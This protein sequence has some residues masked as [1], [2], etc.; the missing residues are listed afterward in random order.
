MARFKNAWNVLTASELPLRIRLTLIL[1]PLGRR[2]K[3]LVKMRLPLGD[4]YLE[5]SPLGIDHRVFTEIFLDGSY[6]T[7][8]I[9]R[10]VL[11]LGAHRGY[12]GAYALHR[13][14]SRVVS[15]EPEARN[16]ELLRRAADSFVSRGSTWEVEHA[17]VGAT[18]GEALLRLRDQSWGH[19]LVDMHWAKVTGTQT[20]AVASLEHGLRRFSK[21]EGPLIVKIDI[22][23]SEGALVMDTPVEAWLPVSELFL[24]IE[25]FC[26][27]DPATLVE[28][29][30]AT[31]LHLVVQ[32]SG[33]I[34]H[35]VR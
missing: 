14:A 24:E 25:P 31:G 34:F 19:T 26:P 17:A 29:L 33:N 11:D 16:F 32:P 22:E 3:R 1:A 9:A 12:F 10:P 27:V 8:Y 7:D 13:G 5:P 4:C 15:Y 20:V 28:R 35:F 30:E 6:A 2:G 21:D 18:D 23:G